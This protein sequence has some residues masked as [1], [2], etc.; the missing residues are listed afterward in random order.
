M[1]SRNKGIFS[2]DFL[3]PNLGLLFAIAVVQFAY[4]TYV[5]PK[6]NDLMLKRKVLA[7]LAKRACA[8]TSGGE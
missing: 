6:A 1:I 4:I 5:T 7:G 3:V 8:V 2:L